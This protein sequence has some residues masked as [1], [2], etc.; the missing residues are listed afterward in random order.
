MA[1]WRL[2][3]ASTFFAHFVRASNAILN[4][5]SVTPSTQH[6]CLCDAALSADVFPNDY[7]CLGDNDNRAIKWLPI[8][9]LMDEAKPSTSSATDAVSLKVFEGEKSPF[10]WSFGVFVWEML[11]SAR[12][13]YENIDA[14]DMYDFLSAGYRLTQPPNCPTLLYVSPSLLR[15]NTCVFQLSIPTRLLATRAC[16]T[17]AN[18]YLRRGISGTTQRSYELHLS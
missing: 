8:E 6:V 11:T 1:M 9:Q 17:T 16:R 3:I 7:E 4:Y 14:D 2:G 15:K 10:Q 13:P 18:E 12:Q 5:F